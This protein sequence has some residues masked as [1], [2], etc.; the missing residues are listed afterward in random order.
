MECN[1]PD[2]PTPDMWGGDTEEL[3]MRPSPSTEL[4][5]TPEGGQPTPAELTKN[6]KS[7]KRPTLLIAEVSFNIVSAVLNVYVMQ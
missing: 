7:T 2:S 5:A 1:P 3:E 4:G 6:K